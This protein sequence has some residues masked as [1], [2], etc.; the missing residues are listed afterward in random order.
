MKKFLCLFLTAM[1]LVGAMIVPIS[2]A[3][4]DDP[5]LNIPENSP[6]GDYIAPQF[7]GIQTRVEG[8][9]DTATQDIRFVATV[10]STQ[11]KLLGFDIYANGKTYELT[12]ASV[13]K[14]INA[15]NKTFSAEEGE[16]LFV[17]VIEDVPTNLTA[18]QFDVRTYVQ[19]GE[20]N[21]EVRSYNTTF[22]MS[23]ATFKKDLTLEDGDWRTQ[24]GT[25]TEENPYVL[26]QENF[27]KFYTANST[28][29]ID[30]GY[31][32]LESNVNV[33][34]NAIAPIATFKGHF[35]GNGN[36]I[37]GLKISGT[38]NTGMFGNLYGGTVSNL[39]LVGATV[40]AALTNYNV[41]GAIAGVMNAGST[42][43]NCYV[44][45]TVTATSGNQNNAAGGIVGLLDNSGTA[46]TIE[47]S[48]FYGAVSFGTKGR[49]G[50]IVGKV[51]SGNSAPN[52]SV[53][54]C[55]FGGT[56]EG[57][58]AGYIIGLNATGTK[59]LIKDCVIDQTAGKGSIQYTNDS[60][61]GNN[62]FEATNVIGRST[63]ANFT[64]EN[65]TF[66][67]PEN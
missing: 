28:K 37:S 34:M 53:K 41:I 10:A 11:G 47:N 59:T 33:T 63:Q 40:E 57:I 42:I 50:G 4:L 14:T 64:I 62:T 16:Y 26:T 15:G 39:R 55:T 2:G 48:Q 32:S 22:E 61:S 66:S 36:T 31:F 45:A 5:T 3:D 58:C 52:H 51:N 7:I 27:E 17:V 8:E 21:T 30:S 38:G 46:C 20:E 54:G 56:A 18:V 13:Y 65:V 60:A 1:L 67:T 24:G 19:Y 43:S 35:N 6:V 9:G 29:D 12:G 49:A 44:D 25:G 23:G